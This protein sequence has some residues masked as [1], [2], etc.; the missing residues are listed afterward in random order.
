MLL[1]VWVL[2]CSA[3][4]A[5]VEQR[6]GEGAGQLAGITQVILIGGSWFGIS[7]AKCIS[8][9]IASLYHLIRHAAEPSCYC[10]APE[11]L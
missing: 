10:L 5:V 2:N 11:D 7:G 9:A 1:R 4:L 6:C 8:R 3:Y